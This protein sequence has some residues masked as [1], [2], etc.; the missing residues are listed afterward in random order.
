M[1]ALATR[2]DQIFPILADPW[3]GDWALDA[4]CRGFGLDYFFEDLQEGQRRGDPYAK[5]RE[6]CGSCPEHVRRCCLATAVAEG[7]R[8]G[9]FGGAI[10]ARRIDIRKAAQKA[11]VDVNT[12]S[13]V[14]R[15]LAEREAAAMEQPN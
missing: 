8:S 6:V 2:S 11:G 13:A 1:A 12:A 14:A 7:L 3:I 9:F 10:P 15:Y 5:A 4:A